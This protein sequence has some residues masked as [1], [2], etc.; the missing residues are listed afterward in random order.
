MAH[1]AEGSDKKINVLRAPTR[2]RQNED[3]QD[4]KRSADVENQVAP[5]VQ[6]PQ[7]GLSRDGRRSRDSLR[8]RE[9]GNVLHALAGRSF[10]KL[11]GKSILVSRDNGNAEARRND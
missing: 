8:G 11:G 7:V 2:L 1:R 9:R 5:T 3:R 10:L 6:N 4:H